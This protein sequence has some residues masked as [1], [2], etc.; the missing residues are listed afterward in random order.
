MAVHFDAAMGIQRDDPNYWRY[1]NEAAIFAELTEVTPI[2]AGIR[3][4]RLAEFG[5]QWPCPTDDHPGTP[6]LHTETYSRG[7]CGKFHAS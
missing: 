6:I 5:L 4:D 2:Y 7:D 1:P 3:H